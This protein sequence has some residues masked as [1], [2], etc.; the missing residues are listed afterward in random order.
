MA[1]HQARQSGWQCGA[2][3]TIPVARELQRRSPMTLSP[4]PSTSAASS[5]PHL[6]FPL[7]VAPPPLG[8]H[9]LAGSTAAVDDERGRIPFLYP[10]D[11]HMRFMKNNSR[12]AQSVLAYV[13]NDEFSRVECSNSRWSSSPVTPSSTHS[14]VSVAKSA[15]YILSWL[16]T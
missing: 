3:C 14:T 5:R 2:R 15:R 9:P 7:P 1:R 4:S 16:T 10:E 6:P 12:I 11:I 8:S 13:I